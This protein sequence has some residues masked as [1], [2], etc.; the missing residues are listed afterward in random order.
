MSQFKIDINKIIWGDNPE[1]N[2]KIGLFFGTF[3]PMHVGHLIIANY[4]VATTDLDEVWFVVTPHNPHKKKAGLLDDHHRLAIV[5]EAVD[6]HDQLK[7]SDIEFGLP[8]PNYTVDTLVH[9][10]EKY[11]NKQFAI[12]MGEDNLRSLHKWKNY[13][14]IIQDHP[15]LVYPRVTTIQEQVKKITDNEL[16]KNAKITRCNAPMMNIS[17]SFIRNCIQQNIDVQFM[18]TEKVCKYIDEMNFYK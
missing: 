4:T 3:N 16:L 13:E 5:K 8:Q 6:N 7:V 11:P 2:K 15:I 10:K 17:A 9:L 14:V 12:L 18:L 1:F